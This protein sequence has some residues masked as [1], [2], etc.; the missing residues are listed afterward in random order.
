MKSF[1][2]L[3]R[4]LGTAALLLILNLAAHAQ[5]AQ[6]TILGH[7]T[8]PSGAVVPGAEVTITNISTNMKFTAKTSAVGDY[9]FVNVTPGQ[10][11]IEVAD[12][13]FKSSHADKV[14]LDVQATLRQNFTLQLGNAQE[15]VEVAADAQMIQADNAT[16][17]GVIESKAIDNLPIS[18]RDFTNLLRLQ[19]GATQVQGSSQLYWA[20][21]GLNNDFASVSINGARTESISYL[22]DGIMLDFE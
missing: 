15:T 19:A 8:D 9:L 12:T 14:Q 22:V 2:R 18:G 17:G 1:Q 20:Q 11:N 3:V 6:G 7:V 4:C 21:H 5:S 10:Y 13:G 16:Q